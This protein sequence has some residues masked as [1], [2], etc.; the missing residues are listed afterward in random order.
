MINIEDYKAYIKDNENF[1]ELLRKNNSL[2]YD[3]LRDLIKVLGYIEFQVDQGKKIEEELKIIF[4]V[5]FSF[6]HEQLEEIKLYFNKYFKRDLSQFLKHELLI[7]YSLYISDLIEVLKEKKKYTDEVKYEFGK[8]QEEI[9]EILRDERNETIDTFDRYNQII[10][11][12]VPVGTL[13]TL[14][15]FALIVEELQI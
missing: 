14:E 6:F 10:E 4:E 5:G 9:E 7:N 8:V 13:T 11:S 1:L 2:V 15:I 12:F 3:R